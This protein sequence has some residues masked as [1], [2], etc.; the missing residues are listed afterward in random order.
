[1]FTNFSAAL[2]GF[3][4]LV[5]GIYFLLKIVSEHTSRDKGSEEVKKES[6]RLNH[7]RH[8]HLSEPLTEYA[9]PKSLGE[10]IGQEDGVRAIASALCGKNPQHIIIYGPPGVG[11]TAAARLAMDMAKESKGTPFSKNAPFV[12]A[13]A[14][15]MRFDERSIA[16]PLIGSVHD[17]IYQGAGAFGVKGIPEPKE[18][19]V[20]KAHGGVLFLDE[21]G[22]LHPMQMNKLLKVLEDRR[23][24]FESSYYSS[25]NKAI[26]LYIHDIFKNGI[27]ADFRL[28][29]A[30]TRKSDEI[31]PA[32]RSRCVE[33]YFSALTLFD[34]RRIIENAM[35][36]T[37]KAFDS[38]VR[39][40]ISLYAQN[41]RDAVKMV[42]TLVN[43]SD[44]DGRGKV[45][46]A[47]AKWVVEAGR[48]SRRTDAYSDENVINISMR[49]YE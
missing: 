21:I 17:P 49:K 26:P 7:M 45:T 5:I 28:I 6:E 16:D 12:E 39:E 24:R 8:I 25:A 22:E 2:Q 15:I 34:I 33:V 23:V 47:D 38:G 48:Y 46:L 40:Y 9:R 32:I 43:I 13:D 35:A 36:K 4:A 1:M 44:M 37:L 42:Q 27:P 11:K 3:A 41:G 14:T 30:T 29:G 31:P 10:I 18:G 19:A 20:S